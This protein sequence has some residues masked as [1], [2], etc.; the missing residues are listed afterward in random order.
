MKKNNIVLL[1]MAMA[2]C[3]LAVYAQKKAGNTDIKSI[4][5]YCKSV[6]AARSRRKAQL[7]VFADTSD[8]AAEGDPK[9]RRFASE[10]ALDK[11]RETTETYTIALNWEQNGRIVASNITLFSPSGDWAKYVYQYFRP[12][13]S[14][15]R[16]ESEVRTFHGEYIAIQRVYFDPRGKLI[17]TTTRYQ[18]LFSKKPRKWD[19]NWGDQ[20]TAFGD[21]DYYKST[22]KLPFAH[23]LGKK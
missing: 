1:V 10:K 19:P 17:R 3:Q 14:L 4:D 11:F 21:V 22:S 13:G 2:A 18:D 15:A 8:Y 6:D 23:L 12:D 16:A 7:V 20:S 5:A 9:W